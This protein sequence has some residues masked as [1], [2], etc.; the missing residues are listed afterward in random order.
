MPSRLMI[1]DRGPR[2][3][4][5]R[6][7]GIEQVLCPEVLLRLPEDYRK[8]LLRYSS[9]IPDPAHLK[10]RDADGEPDVREVHDFLRIDPDR[11]D[12][13]GSGLV[14]VLLNY[15][16]MLPRF[17]IPIAHLD[18]DDLLLLFFAGPRERQVWLWNSIAAESG[19]WDFDPE[20]GI[21]LVAKTFAAILKL[22]HE[23]KV[24]DP[25]EPVTFALDSAKVRDQRLAAIL[26]ALGCK[27][28]NY[29]TGTYS[30]LPDPPAWHWPKYEST[31][32]VGGPAYLEMEKNKA[33]GNASKFD[34][35]PA[36]HPML[37]V[38]VTKLKR[39]TC[40]REL[41]A[42]LGPGAVLLGSDD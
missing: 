11:L 2:L 17:A 23:P 42:A 7:N 37:R 13:P 8:F 32:D 21:R 39:A 41:A 14:W 25:Y 38:N 6:L 29:R 31:R 22:L 16:A 26:K 28:W 4:H 36:G 19:D 5:G 12:E 33:D 35:R 24:S 1:R 34:D 30:N 40:L 15:R 9:G 27:R 10:C 18:L 20:T 3:T